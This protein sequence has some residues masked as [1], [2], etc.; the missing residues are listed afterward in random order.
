MGGGA[1]GSVGEGPSMKIKDKKMEI[2]Y[3]RV[4]DVSIL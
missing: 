1:R 2:L 4:L 3:F